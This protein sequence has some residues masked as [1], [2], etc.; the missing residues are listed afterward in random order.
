MNRKFEGIWIPREVWLSE[1][2]TLQEKVF[3]VEIS[4]LD[5]ANGCY[6]NNEYFSKFFGISKTR[7]S[8]I[9]NALVQKG[10][11][12]SYI[13]V[14]EGNKRYLKTLLNFSLRP[15]YR[16]VQDPLKESCKHNNTVNN[17]SNNTVSTYGAADD[18]EPP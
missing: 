1:E 2:M 5:N 7:V 3:L 13:K 18:L 17:T 9:I 16:N 12:T 15:S 8:N 6:A 4:S 11:L 10:L 14:E